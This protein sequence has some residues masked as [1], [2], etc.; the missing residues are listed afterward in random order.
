M[1]K[2]CPECKGLMNYDPYFKAEV[3]ENCGAM[4]RVPVEDLI[5]SRLATYISHLYEKYNG[6]IVNVSQR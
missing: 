1:C 6:S 5:N 4:E 3:C 2:I